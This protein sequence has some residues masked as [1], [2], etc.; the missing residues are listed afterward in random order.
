MHGE[1]RLFLFSI[2]SI[3]N[4]IKIYLSAR[5]MHDNVNKMQQNRI[6]EVKS[7]KF[8]WLDETPW[9]SPFQFFFGW[10]ISS[11]CK[12]PYNMTM[13]LINVFRSW[14]ITER[15]KTESEFLT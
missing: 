10:F 3:L 5:N 2:I 6:W 12:I 14:E 1:R 13:N 11:P 8:P 4:K 9:F 7:I 15:K